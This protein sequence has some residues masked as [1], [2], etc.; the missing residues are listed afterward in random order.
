MAAELLGLLAVIALLLLAA[1]FAVY[2][3]ITH[4]D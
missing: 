1:G 2:Y 3:M 4:R